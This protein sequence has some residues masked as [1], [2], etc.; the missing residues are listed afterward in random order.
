MR[1]DSERAGVYRRVRRTAEPLKLKLQQFGVR[2][3]AEFEAPFAEMAAKA[4]RRG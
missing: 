4:P 1:F 3:P 2:K